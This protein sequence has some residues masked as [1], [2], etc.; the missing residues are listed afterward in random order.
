MVAGRPGIADR[1]VRAT[2]SDQDRIPADITGPIAMPIAGTAAL[3][4]FGTARG[5]IAATRRI[6]AGCPTVPGNSQSRAR[7]ADCRI[8]GIRAAGQNRY[9]LFSIP[10]HESACRRSLI[11][12]TR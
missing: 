11:V 5:D 10:G 8:P 9:V 1:A 2:G 12:D 4:D 6:M 7:R 3:P